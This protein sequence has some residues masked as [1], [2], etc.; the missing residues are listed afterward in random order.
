MIDDLGEYWKA[1]V[2]TM[3]DGVV[4]VSI[5]GIIVTINKAMENITGYTPDELVGKPCLILDCEGCFV[6]NQTGQKEKTCSLYASGKVVRRRCQ[7]RKKDGSAFYVLKN[8]TVLKDSAGTIIGGVE[9]LTDITNLVEK[10]KAIEELK[11]LLLPGDAF[12]GII[13][14]ASKIKAVKELILN[15]AASD[16]PVIIYGESGTG[17][18]LVANADRKSVV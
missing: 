8:A 17:K 11:D 5:D 13:G 15:A 6:I 1:I 14:N 2:D 3:M 10:E 16:A 4:V 12:E 7:L 18:E 9:T